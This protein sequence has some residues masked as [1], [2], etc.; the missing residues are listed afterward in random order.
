MFGPDKMGDIAGET[1]ML[2]K[3]YI[4]RAV[5]IECHSSQSQ[6]AVQ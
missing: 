2:F 4:V 1:L 5:L 3:R 6:Q